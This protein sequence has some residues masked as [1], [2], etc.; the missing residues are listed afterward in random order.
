MMGVMSTP[1]DKKLIMRY[2]LNYCKGA[3]ITDAGWTRLRSNLYPSFGKARYSIYTYFAVRSSG[4]KP[5]CRMT[6]GGAIGSS[7]G[8]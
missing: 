1:L 8:S 5:E 6:R 3:I 4:R 7:Q 2:Y